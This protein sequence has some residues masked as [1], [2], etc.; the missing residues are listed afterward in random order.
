MPSVTPTNQLWHPVACQRCPSLSDDSIARTVAKMD[1]LRE[2]HFCLDSSA[3]RKHV[4]LGVVFQ[5][6]CG[7][8]ILHSVSVADTE[9]D[10]G[11]PIPICSN[12]FVGGLIVGNIPTSL[13]GGVVRR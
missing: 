7:Y 5:A 3:I 4:S 8:S 2:D 12:N 13:V 10:T 6:K 9:T 11:I 1:A